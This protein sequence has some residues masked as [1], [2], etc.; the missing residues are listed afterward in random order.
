MTE[1]G[2]ISA[3]LEAELRKQAR[4]Y[5]ILVWLD[6]E[7]TYTAFADALAARAEAKAFPVPVR[8]LRG[9]YLELMLG[10]EDLEDG[11]GMTPLIVHVP[12]HTEESIAETPASS[13]MGSSRRPSAEGLGGYRGPLFFS[14]P[15][16]GRS[17]RQDR[18]G[19]DCFAD[20][21]DRQNATVS[22]CHQQFTTRP[23]SVQCCNVR[24]SRSRT[25]SIRSPRHGGSAA[26]RLGPRRLQITVPS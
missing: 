22:S 23:S 6:K 1:P 5:G 25:C 19:R 14:A 10:L 26:A 11:V 2:S 9:S 12:G 17:L 7:G 20:R 13:I 21:V 15:S 24:T 8:R 4:Q 18:R 16:R 3:S